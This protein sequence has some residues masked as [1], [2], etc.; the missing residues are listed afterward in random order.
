MTSLSAPVQAVLDLF[1]GPLAD[2]R[3]ADVDAAGLANLAA[4]VD[5]AAGEVA[6]QEAQLAELRQTLVERQDA[7]LLLAQRAVA[8]ARVYAEHDEALTEQLARITLPRAA[9]PRKAGAAKAPGE[10]SAPV[11]AAPVEVESA[12]VAP[13]QEEPTEAQVEEPAPAPAIAGSR[14]TKRRL[15]PPRDAQSRPS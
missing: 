9:K 5:S 7:L 10:A 6:R 2:V 15:G 13:A 12:A 11:E 14:K 1:Q 8:Y 4:A 3:F